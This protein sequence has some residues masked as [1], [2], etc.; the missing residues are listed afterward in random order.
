MPLTFIHTADWQLGKPFNGYPSD[1]APHLQ[2]VRLDGIDTIAAAAR[3][4]SARHV[5]VAGDVFD[6]RTPSADLLVRTFAK[7][8]AERDLVW[9]L[10]PGNHD[11]AETGSFWLRPPSVSRPPNIHLLATAAPIEIEPGVYLLPAPLMAKAMATDPTAWMDTS[12]T[13]VGAMRIGVAHGSV[14]GF[15]TDGDA[16]VL[17]APDRPGRARLDYLALGDWH[18]VTRISERC[19]YSGTHEPDQF[20]SNRP[21]YVLRVDIDRADAVPR[22]T[23]VATGHFKWV[24]RT[25]KVSSARDLE[26]LVHDIAALGPAAQR[27]LLELTLMG[28][29][30]LTELGAI[31]RQLDQLAPTVRHLRRQISRLS[32]VASLGDVEHLPI[33]AVRDIALQLR[34]EADTDRPDAAYALKTLL[35]LAASVAGEAG[36]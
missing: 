7:L 33:G 30:T 34:R 2:Q 21:G 17:I 3:A 18:G 15:G 24:G 29:V 36:R 4:A 31:E 23:E 27:T 28:Q 1:V 16:A 6:S 9:H 25:L 5:I 13:P 11:P 22:V 26:P 12:V 10:L 35:R 32:A 8:G 20:P 14:Q 19:F